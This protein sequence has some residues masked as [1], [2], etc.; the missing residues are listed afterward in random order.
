V[1]HRSRF[2]PV[3]SLASLHHFHTGAPRCTA[4]AAVP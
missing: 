1:T 2:P 3:L 4:R